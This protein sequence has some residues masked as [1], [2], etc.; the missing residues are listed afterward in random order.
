[1]EMMVSY[2]LKVFLKQKSLFETH[3]VQRWSARSLNRFPLSI[4]I[5]NYCYDR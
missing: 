5:P 4:P 1:M 2:E 3:K